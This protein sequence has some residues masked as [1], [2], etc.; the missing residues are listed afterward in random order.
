[1]QCVAVCL[2]RVNSQK[3]S[4]ESELS[5]EL[6]RIDTVSHR[7]CVL[8]VLKPEPLNPK[9]VQGGEDLQVIFRKR[10]TN[11]KA[12]WRKMT[13]K[14]KVSYASSPPFSSK[15]VIRDPLF[16]TI[17]VRVSNSA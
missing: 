13:C 12:L 11:K 4:A 16:V 9:T 10:A 2:L 3:N 1:M 15:L 7:Y 14:D 17:Y 8:R 6:S 5:E